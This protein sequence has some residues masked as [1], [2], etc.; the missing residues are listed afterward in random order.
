ML[1]KGTC[2]YRCIT[3]YQE[4]GSRFWPAPGVEVLFALYAFAL[5]LGS[6]GL[7]KEVL[8]IR[9]LLQ[10]RSGYICRDGTV[11]SLVHDR[12]LFSPQ[13]IRR[14]FLASMMVATPMVM[15]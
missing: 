13:A 6:S 12:G 2:I 11:D 5:Q 7:V 1:Q 3:L 9:V 14:S 8:G 10:V 4:N 15:A